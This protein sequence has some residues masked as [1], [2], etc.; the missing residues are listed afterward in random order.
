MLAGQ[1][2]SRMRDNFMHLKQRFQLRLDS[3]GAMALLVASNPLVQKAVAER[4]RKTL[5]D[6]YQNMCNELTRQ[7]GIKQFHFHVFPGYSFLRL[8][9]PEKHS[10]ELS[11][12]RQTISKAYETGQVV[13]GLEYGVTGFGLRGVAPI[14]YQ[15]ELVGSVEIGWSLE[16]PFLKRYQQ[17][18]DSNISLYLPDSSA[19]NGF[20]VLATTSKPLTFIALPIY[21]KVMGAGE[22]GFMTSKMGDRNLA[23]LVGPVKDFQG[24]TMAAIELVR[25]RA[26]TLDLIHQHTT[27]ILSFALV[28]LVLALVFV[29]WISALF[30]APIWVLVDQAE[31]ITA[32]ERVPHMEITVR[33][34]FG[35]LAESLNR[36]LTRL[37]ESRFRLQNQAQELEIK[38]QE[39]RQV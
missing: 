38:V 26:G 32:G 1:E 10:D 25:D 8:H 37:E 31:K 27:V 20:Q 3:A 14:F 30:L 13:T 39:P 7:V 18:F 5:T 35:T 15:G 28:I 33:D 2:E 29:W 21:K 9:D 4:D 36:M 16:L 19:P 23:V 17:D 24:R 11:S 22:P 6:L 12:Y 34:E